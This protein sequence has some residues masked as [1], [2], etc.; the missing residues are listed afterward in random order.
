MRGGFNLGGEQSGHV[1]FLD[2]TT[3][4]DGIITALAVLALMVEN[5]PAAL[6]LAQ[7]M[8]AFSAGAG[9]RPGARASATWPPCRASLQAMAAVEK[10]A[11]RR[12]AASSCATPGRSRFSA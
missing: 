5:G 10:R 2:H 9:Q 12:A 1:V 6:E 3:T 4:G 7:V 8:T 11:R